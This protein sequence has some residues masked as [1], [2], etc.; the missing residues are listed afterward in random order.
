MIRA[1]LKGF[2]PEDLPHT[3]TFSNCSHISVRGVAIGCGHGTSLTGNF[4]G[5][6]GLCGFHQI[7]SVEGNVIN[8]SS[9]CLCSF[10]LVY[11]FSLGSGLR[12]LMF[13]S[14]LLLSLS[15]LSSPFSDP[16][17]RLFSLS[18]RSSFSW[19]FSVF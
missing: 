13:R 15:L 8:N 19:Y 12:L 14:S 18:S 1:N 17:L 9:V 10:Y 3:A 6:T 4:T 5:L 16:L 7:L 2:S 11:L